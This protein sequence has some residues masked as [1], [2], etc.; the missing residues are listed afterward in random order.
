MIKW[1]DI[2][3]LQ[4]IDRLGHILHKWHGIKLFLSDSLGNVQT[5]NNSPWEEGFICEL[6]E[7]NCEVKNSSQRMAVFDSGRLFAVGLFHEGEYL[8]AVWGRSLFGRDVPAKKVEY[9]GELLALAGDEIIRYSREIS[10]KEEHIHT[11]NREVGKEVSSPFHDRQVT[12]D[13]GTLWPVG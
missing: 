4:G 5:E 7:K 2:R 6:K 11:L 1:E 3:R 10:G 9:L 13:D 12:E 8:G